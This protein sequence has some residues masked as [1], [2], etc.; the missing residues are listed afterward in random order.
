[1]V[2]DGFLWAF[3]G[4]VTEGVMAFIGKRWRGESGPSFYGYDSNEILSLSNTQGGDRPF[5]SNEDVSGYSAE[6]GFGEI[7]LE[8]GGGG[9]E[10]GKEEGEFTWSNMRKEM[11]CTRV[12]LDWGFGNMAWKSLFLQAYTCVL[13]VSHSDHIPISLWRRRKVSWGGR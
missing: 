3:L 9:G 10:R 12:K 8:G 7:A 1:M 2:F 6:N 5:I 11:A 4:R 13:H